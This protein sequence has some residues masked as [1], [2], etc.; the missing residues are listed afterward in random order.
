MTQSLLFVFSLFFMAVSAGTRDNLK[1]TLED[2]ER[3]YITTRKQTKLTPPPAP[4][5]PAKSPTQFGFV[6]TKTLSNYIQKEPKANYDFQ[7]QLGDFQQYL[8]GQQ[9][10]SGLESTQG[11][12]Y[13]G[14]QKY[15]EGQQYT[16]IVPE[17]YSSIAPTYSGPVYTGP[18]KKPAVQAYYVPQGQGQYQGFEKLQYLSDNSIAQQAVQQYY[19]PQYVYLQPNQAPTSSVQTIVDPKGSL[20]YLMY[21]P[22][23]Q[24]PSGEQTQNYDNV[25]NGGA[26][27]TSY[28]LPQ[29]APSYN[30]IRYSQK[31]ESTQF[32]QPKNLYTKA[33]FGAKRE[34]KSLLDSYVPSA[35]QL[36]YFRQA[37][38]N[39][40]QDGQSFG[41]SHRHNYRAVD[42]GSIGNYNGRPSQFKH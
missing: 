36:Q 15:A 3:D 16:D 9:Y 25:H 41:K 10:L 33:E 17:K 1:T 39:A 18:S 21:L 31:D 4:K 12:Q 38:Q 29:Q 14:G 24:N 26:E 32:E 8:G 30:T 7:F 42:S 2:I 13:R 11:E 37:H 6:P 19:T 34:P 27:Q 20:H 22:A 40:I 28:Q 5:I 35:L 23:Y